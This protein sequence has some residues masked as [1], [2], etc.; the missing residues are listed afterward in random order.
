MLKPDTVSPSGANARRR[1]FRCQPSIGESRGLARRRLDGDEIILVHAVDREIAIIARHQIDG[2]AG[3]CRFQRGGDGW[4]GIGAAARWIDGERSGCLARRLCAV[5]KK[6]FAVAAWAAVPMEAT[7][8]KINVVNAR[9]RKVPS[10]ISSY[11]QKNSDATR[12]TYGL[13]PFA[14]YRTQ[15]H[16]IVIDQPGTSRPNE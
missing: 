8:T 9:I 10:L 16:T 13:R 3:L 2:V 14:R 12:R 11:R 15:L 7:A 4:I 1:R 5:G 6:S